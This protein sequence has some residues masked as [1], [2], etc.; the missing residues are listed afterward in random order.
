MLE[1]NSNPGLTG[2]KAHIFL[3]GT[4]TS[5]EP[6]GM[7][8]TKTQLNQLAILTRF[9]KLPSGRVFSFPQGSPLAQAK[10]AWLLLLM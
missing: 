2:P 4:D 5:G 10:K 7:S 3:L 9:P 1:E 8:T 6:A